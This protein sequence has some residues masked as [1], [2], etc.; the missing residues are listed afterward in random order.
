MKQGKPSFSLINFRGTQKQKAFKIGKGDNNDRDI[1]YRVVRFL[2]R[3]VKESSMGPGQSW[4]HLSRP[5]C[6]RRGYPGGGPR[7]VG[8]VGSETTC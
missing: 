3:C 1:I 7:R 8:D 5:V 4:R 2:F 6:D